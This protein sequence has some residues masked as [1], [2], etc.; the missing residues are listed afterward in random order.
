MAKGPNYAG[1]IFLQAEGAH[2]AKI[3]HSLFSVKDA[4]NY[5][6]FHCATVYKVKSWGFNFIQNRRLLTTQNR[7]LLTTQSR[8]GYKP[9][10]HNITNMPK[11]HF[12]VFADDHLGKYGLNNFT[13]MAHN[14]IEQAHE[15]NLFS[16]IHFYTAQSL[17]EK[18]PEYLKAHG[19]YINSNFQKSIWKGY[20]Y[21]IWKPFLIWKTLC[22][23]DEGDVL[24]YL[25][26]K[27]SLHVSGKDRFM[28]YLD[29]LDKSENKTV[30][31]QYTNP[32][33]DWCKMDTIKYFGVEKLVL[34][35]NANEIAP[36]I[37]LTSST[38]KNKIFFK[39]FY[40]ESCN[41]HNID[42][43]PS[44]SPN[45]PSFKEHRHDQ[46]ILS[47]L[48]IKFYASSILLTSFKE[49]YLP[50]NDKS[51]ITIHSN[52]GLIT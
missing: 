23:I 6:V 49:F 25:D 1:D 2:F 30:L 41:Y 36:G 12:L 29:I 18:Y 43:S 8:Q 37:I 13:N 21:W 47:I 5:K 40:D 31:V 15:F 26:A 10:K 24:L 7:R 11:L 39:L 34:E 51:P 50:E 52:R 20:G 4:M 19:E 28:E 14:L 3:T 44:I 45:I 33:K 32:I 9:H 35:D 27:C 22:E 17:F 46:T 42:D 48:A 38:E 16:K